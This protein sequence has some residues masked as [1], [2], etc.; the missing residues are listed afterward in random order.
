MHLR[1]EL[2]RVK[3]LPGPPAVAS[4]GIG[5][6]GD[7]RRPSAHVEPHVKGEYW[8]KPVACGGTSNPCRKDCRI[9]GTKPRRYH[10]RQESQESILV[11]GYHWLHLISLELSVIR[12]RDN[13]R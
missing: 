1:Q 8:A 13:I 12:S 10:R 6:P 7:R 11:P 5:A 3:S 2:P 4:A 9:C